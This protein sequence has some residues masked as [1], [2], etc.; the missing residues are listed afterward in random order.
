MGPDAVFLGRVTQS[1]QLDVAPS[2]GDQPS[3]K[4]TQ[5]LVERYGLRRAGARAPLS[6]YTRELWRRRHFIVEFSRATNA[7]GYAKSVLGQSWQLLTPLLNAGVYFFVFG[8]LMKASRGVPNYIGYLVIGIFVF[9]FITK[10]MNMGARALQSNIS[11]VRTLRFPRAVFPLSATTIALE[12]M[13]MSLV[14]MIPI[15]LFTG[16]PIRLQWLE[17]IPALALQTCFCMGVAFMCARIGAKLPDV[18]QMLPFVTRLWLYASGVMFSID[19]VTKDMP[20][21]VGT[22]LNSNPAAELMY[23]YRGALLSDGPA[24]TMHEWFIAFLWCV[25][26]LIA[27]YVFFWKAEEDYGHE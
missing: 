11:L 6:E 2:S 26:V 5:E 19:H 27:G 17:I 12:Q 1:G 10:S 16:E 13:L 7:S 22:V 18:T 3:R 25:G 21:I 8:L 24:A 9:E 14:V 20:E 23:L 4:A 15:V